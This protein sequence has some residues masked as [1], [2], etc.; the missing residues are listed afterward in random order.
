MEKKRDLHVSYL[1][2]RGGSLNIQDTV[3]TATATGRDRVV[4]TPKALQD[5]RDFLKK[6][7]N[8][9]SIV[10]ISWQWFDDSLNE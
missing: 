8:V 1:F 6:E 10:I 7:H 3:F 4:I 5:I 2:E 9:D